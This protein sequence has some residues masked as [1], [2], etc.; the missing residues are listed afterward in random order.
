MPFGPEFRRTLKESGRPTRLRPNTAP[1]PPPRKSL[2]QDILCKPPPGVDGRTAPTTSGQGPR[3]LS[4][5]HQTASR[6]MVRSVALNITR[7]FGTRSA[8]QA[9]IQ[10]RLGATVRRKAKVMRGNL[11]TQSSGSTARGSFMQSRSTR[12]FFNQYAADVNQEA[13]GPC[14]AIGKK[15]GFASMLACEVGSKGT[16]TQEFAPRTSRRHRPRPNGTPTQV[17]AMDARVARRASR[18]RP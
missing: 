10:Q 17:S 9:A 5:P 6:I 18:H 4:H 16:S 2:L 13:T 3:M 1:P 14:R 7:S 15:I 11:D 8:G 12:Y